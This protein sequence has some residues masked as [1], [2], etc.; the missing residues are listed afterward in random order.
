MEFAFFVLRDIKDKSNETV[1]Y[2]LKGLL[3]REII[4]FFVSNTK[5]DVSTT[6]NSFT[7]EER[8]KLVRDLKHF[9]LSFDGLD[10]IDKGIVTSGGV[11]VKEINQQSMESKIIPGLYFIG[12]VLDV[13]AL[14]GGFNLQI[15]LS[16]AYAAASHI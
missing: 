5:T 16:T 10:D 2:L 3:P 7:K 8:A 11:S 9:K 15:A 6:L 14:T 13:D 12:E 1:A 4:P